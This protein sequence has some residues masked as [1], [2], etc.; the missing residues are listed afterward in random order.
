M[1]LPE[2]PRQRSVEV[3]P[4]MTTKRSPS[5]IVVAG[6]APRCRGFSGVAAQPGASPG[7]RDAK[8]LPA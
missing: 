7:Q 6:L 1:A 8:T 3:A 4:A 5:G 2:H